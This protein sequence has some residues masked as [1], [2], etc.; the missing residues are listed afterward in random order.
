VKPFF[1]ALRT[2]G[3]EVVQEDRLLV[4]LGDILVHDVDV[5][6]ARPVRVRSRRVAED[7]EEVRSSLR[8]GD[9][10]AE[11]TRRDL[12]G[13]D[14]PSRT[15]VGEMARG[16]PAR[17]TQVEHARRFEERPSDAALLQVRG[18]LAAL[19]VPPP[20]F[21]AV[22]D[23]KRLA[24]HGAAGHEVPRVEPG[25]VPEHADVVCRANRHGRANPRAAIETS[26]ACGTSGRP[27]SVGGA[28]GAI[29]ISGGA[30]ANASSFHA[31]VRVAVGGRPSSACA[32][33]GV[34]GPRPRRVP[35]AGCEARARTP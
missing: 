1:S 24:V 13:D 20:V 26:V 4:P 2:K 22:L 18:E 16:R 29:R 3:G 19:R 28:D 27:A 21:D 14:R 33:R 30:P 8:N 7:R 12:D 25:T 15:D 9:K 5:A 32:A 35:S 6:D 11:R 31:S 23:A 34:V 17:G 10:V